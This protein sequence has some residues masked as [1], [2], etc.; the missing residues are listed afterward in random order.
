MTREKGAYIRKKGLARETNKALLLKHIEEN[1]DS[2]SHLSGLM[3]VLPA[4]SDNQGKNSL[5]NLKTRKKFIIP[6]PLE[7]PCGIQKDKIALGR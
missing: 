4:L 7:P 5:P 1:K 6:E 2:G 3:Q